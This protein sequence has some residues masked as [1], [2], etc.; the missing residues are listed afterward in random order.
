MGQHHVRLQNANGVKLEESTTR[1][2]SPTMDATMTIQP[3]ATASS[4]QYAIN[5]LV[6]K[7]G[8]SDVEHVNVRIPL[9]SVDSDLQQVAKQLLE[10]HGY[11]VDPN[12]AEKLWAH[13]QFQR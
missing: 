5:E 2:D 3:D 6:A 7:A 12:A 13:R 9:D 4:V 11:D 10:K 8:R 1:D